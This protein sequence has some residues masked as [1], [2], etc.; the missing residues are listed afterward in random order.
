MVEPS[1]EACTYCG[2]LA[3]SPISLH[4]DIVE[5]IAA[6]RDY[7]KQVV[8]MAHSELQNGELHDAKLTLSTA[9]TLS[10]NSRHS[11]KEEPAP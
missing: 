8:E 3:P 1:N 6:E 2:T 4:H 9:L 11:S 10:A 5:C 7:L